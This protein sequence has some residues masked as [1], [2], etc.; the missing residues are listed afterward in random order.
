MLLSMFLSPSKKNFITQT[1]YICTLVGSL[2]CLFSPVTSIPFL[3]LQ[4]IEESLDDSIVVVIRQLMKI[5]TED[6]SY[7]LDN[8]TKI[9]IALIDW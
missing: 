8:V 5:S 9:A 1:S 2:L 3:F 6:S 7:L 4:L